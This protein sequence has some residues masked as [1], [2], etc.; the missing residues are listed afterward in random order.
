MMLWVV[1]SD[2]D[3]CD[4]GILRLG[5]PILGQRVNMSNTN[6]LCMLLSWS[7]HQGVRVYRRYQYRKV[8]IATATDPIMMRSKS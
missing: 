8:D 5:M 4:F 3:N 7:I 1:N 2:Y 6:K